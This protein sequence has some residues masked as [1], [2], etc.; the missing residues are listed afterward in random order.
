VEAIRKH[1]PESDV[2][3]ISNEN[4]P[5]YS[6]CLLSY[7][8]ADSIDETGLLFRSRDFHQEMGVKVILG[9]KVL[10]VNPADQQVV[11]NDGTKLNYD[12]L[13]IATGS[14]PMIP[15]NINK[16][17]NGVFVLRNIANA[18]AI[19]K[20]INA[21]NNAVV[22][23]GGLV[24]LKAAFALNKQ[25]LNV[26][27]VE[28]S[29]H[30]LPQI[31]DSKAAQIILEKLC[32][33]GIKL[34][35]KTV[36]TEIE[37]KVGKLVAVKVDDCLYSK[38]ETTE[39]VI[40]CDILVV[41]GGVEPNMEL[42]DDTGIERNWGIVTNANM[43]TSVDTIYAAGDVAE[44]SDIATKQR[45]VNAL[46]TC[47]VQQGKIAGLNMTG[48][49]RKYDGSVSLNS[50][51]FP[52]VDVI[53]FGVVRPNEEAGYEVLVDNR[54]QYGVYK[55][56]VLKDNIIKGMILV[57]RIDNAGVLLSLLGRK[58]NT[59]NFKD[60]LI[61]DTFSYAKVLGSRG[62]DELLRYWSAARTVRSY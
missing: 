6:R 16:D 52:G 57:N 18:K 26:T 19:K 13:L 32:E 11:C 40:P 29:N 44:T 61:S 23:G 1:D 37:S 5:L 34:L 60:E 47:A 4:Y 58:I 38:S 31:V 12:K 55:K 25:G 3:I 20:R 7:F 50:I 51:N 39:R 41:A 27:V 15:S 45:S 56:L 62:R 43:Q 8:L 21:A 33:N 59:A 46:W 9:R 17:I 28:Y 53:S 54:S 30:V 22:L 35:T 49:Q 10:S 48:H 2:T 14:S 24:G 42:I 36:I